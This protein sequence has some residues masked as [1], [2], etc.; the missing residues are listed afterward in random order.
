MKRIL[1]LVLVLVLALGSVPVAFA[2]T[3]TEGDMLKAAGFVAGDQD[4]NLNEDQKL[5]REQMMVLIAEMNGVKEEAATFGI[6]FDFS[7]VNENDWFAPYVWYAAYQGW[8]AGMGDGS[9]GAGVAVDSKM[10]ATFMLKALDYDVADY[11]ASV[12]QAADMGIEITATSEMTRGEGFK[13]MWSTVNL[14]KQGSD[15]ALGVELGKIETTEEAGGELEAAVLDTV[16]AI[17]AN[18]VYVEFDAEVAAAAAGDEANYVIVEKDDATKTVEVLEAQVDSD[19]IVV[20][21]T[22][23]MKT[24]TAYT[25]TVDESSVNF[26]GISKESDTPELKSVKAV[27]GDQIEVKFDMKV[28]AVTAE[29]VANYSI[30]KEGTVVKAELDKEDRDVV[31]LTVEGFA[32]TSSKK[33]TVENVTSIDDVKMSKEYRTFTPKFDKKSPK[34]DAVKASPYNNVEVIINFDDDHGVDKET[35]EDVSNYAIDGLEIY[36]AKAIDVDE[37]DNSSDDDDYYN[38]V[39]L[40]TSEQSKS[41]SYTLKVLNMV[42]GST[43]KKCYY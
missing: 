17:S 32:T 14:P 9:F 31:T 16:E 4:G 27:D 8:T 12:E 22:A 6:P 37:K 7:D 11:N 20:L 2:A 24:G 1:S 28:T 41:K 42:D 5:T 18:R 10:A 38:R 26:T 25:L 21:K 13:A 36:S 34:I 29:D 30:D 33:L 35:A 40:T 19:V 15:V 3:E 43:A 23:S 39:V